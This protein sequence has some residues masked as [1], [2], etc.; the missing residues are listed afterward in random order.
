MRRLLFSLIGS[1]IWAASS[2]QTTPFD[3]ASLL[4]L[5]QREHID[6]IEQLL[7]SLPAEQR[8]HYAVMFESRSLQSASFENP[9]VI[10]FGPDARFIVTFNGSPAQRG[11]STL[12]TMEFD[13]QTKQFR[14]REL[15]FAASSCCTQ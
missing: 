7:A 1:A 2:A 11:F 5:L 4:S 14:L 6:S 15:Q 3:F 13:E 9:R 8:S 10:L 12:E